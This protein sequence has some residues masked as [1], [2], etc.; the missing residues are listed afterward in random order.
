RCNTRCTICHLGDSGE[1]KIPDPTPAQI[2]DFVRNNPFRYYVLSGGE[3][4]CRDDI[5]QIVGLLKKHKKI[6]T[7]NTNGIKL[8]EQSYVKRLRDHG[9]DRINLQFDGF[10]RNAYREFRGRDL[11]DDKLTV[12]RNLE[13]LSV[14]TDLN[15]TVAKGINDAALG[16]IID[17]AAAH[18][19][20]NAINFFTLCYL[21][22][23]R[24]WPLSRNIMPDGVGDALEETTRGKITKRDIYLFQKLHLALKSFSNQ[25]FCLYTQIFVLFRNKGGYEPISLFL[26]L[27]RAEWVLDRY[28]RLS[29]QNRLLGKIFLVCFLPFALLR[30]SSGAILAELVRTGVSFFLKQRYHVCSRKFLYLNFNTSCD[31]YNLDSSIACNCHDEIVY[32]GIDDGVLANQG[33]DGFRAIDFEKKYRGD[34][35]KNWCKK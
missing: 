33:R 30:R 5:F 29:P 35:S 10:D 18:N 28:A 7:I 34:C 6:V 17:F 16:P 20:I 31:P 2:D 1:I 12:L 19:F 23:V 8:L 9:V 14:S 15:V 25:R 32:V 24:N 22:D 21:G 26:N 3:P 27:P 4:T 13:G 11:L